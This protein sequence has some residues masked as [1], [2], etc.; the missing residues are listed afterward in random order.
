[1]PRT[2]K[3]S[4]VRPVV[5]L[6][7]EARRGSIQARSQL[8]EL[9]RDYLLLIA[10]R[11]M[12][13]RLKSKAGASDLVQET[14]LEAYCGFERFRGE[15]EAEFYCWIRRILK[16]NLSNFTRCYGDTR[17]RRAELEVSIE[18]VVNC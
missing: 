18:Q 6:L 4:V 15:S 2:S 14:I 17:K 7:T 5:T 12:E 9:C 11:E 10:N 1:M 13:G 16:N 3:N 8:F